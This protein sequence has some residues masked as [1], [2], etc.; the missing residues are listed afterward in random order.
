VSAPCTWE[1]IEKGKVD[2][3]TF[4]LRNMPERVEAVGDLWAGV[5]RKGR[6]LKGPAEKLRRLIAPG[7]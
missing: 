3:G 1:E 2:P 6:S 4:N 5:L 7:S